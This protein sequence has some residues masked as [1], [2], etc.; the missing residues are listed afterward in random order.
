M[1]DACPQADVC[2]QLLHQCSCAG[3]NQPSWSEAAL[4]GG[5]LP[6]ACASWLFEECYELF[7]D[8][9]LGPYHQEREEQDGRLP[10]PEL[11]PVP[12]SHIQ[13]RCQCLHVRYEQAIPPEAASL[14]HIQQSMK[15]CAPGRLRAGLIWMAS[16]PLCAYSSC[17][18][19]QGTLTSGKRHLMVG[20]DGEA[21]A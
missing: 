6:R 16:M 20:G 11:E 9:F 8:S 21:V 18:W 17:R 19:L 1:Q 12:D 10:A 4:L 14:I 3:G 2:Y 7:E 15:W 13:V 5:P